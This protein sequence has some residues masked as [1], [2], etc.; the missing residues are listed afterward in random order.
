MLPRVFNALA[1][2]M[3]ARRTKSFMVRLFSRNTRVD[4][5]GDDENEPKIRGAGS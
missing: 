5:N 2:E 1:L 3:V 4:G